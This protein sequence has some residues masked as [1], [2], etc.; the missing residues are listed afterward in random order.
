MKVFVPHAQDSMSR[1]GAAALSGRIRDWWA[2]RGVTLEPETERIV[3]GAVAL[4]FVRLPPMPGRPRGA[5][6]GG[7]DRAT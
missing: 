6:V 2:R 5:T 4:H 7:R 3:M 1:D